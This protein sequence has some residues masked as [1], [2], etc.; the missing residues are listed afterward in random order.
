VNELGR[1]TTC[2]HTSVNF[3]SWRIEEPPVKESFEAG[4]VEWVGR[5]IDRDI[6]HASLE[7]AREG[8]ESWMK[9]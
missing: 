8:E 7:P 2:T 5:L 4:L 1:K 9:I 3:E 6:G